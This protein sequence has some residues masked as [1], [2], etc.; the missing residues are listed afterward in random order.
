MKRIAICLTAGLLLS[1][2]PADAGLFGCF[3]KKNTCQPCPTVCAAPVV[4]A[5]P[6]V[7]ACDSGCGEVVS[8]PVETISYQSAPVAEAASDCGCSGAVSEGTIVS[9]GAVMS[10]EVISSDSM[11]GS[12]SSPTLAPSM[13]PTDGLPPGAVIINNDVGGSSTE[14]YSPPAE[15]EDAPKPPA[16]E[17]EAKPQPKKNDNAGNAKKNMQNQGG[18]QAQPGNTNQSENQQNAG[19]VIGTEDGN[20]NGAGGPAAKDG[21]EL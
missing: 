8:A 2:A 14:S 1:A 11:S 3:K 19:T 4:E 5:A 17:K 7:S 9:D 21:P 20:T 6:V 18:A 16:E 12:M 15:V 10:G 13:S